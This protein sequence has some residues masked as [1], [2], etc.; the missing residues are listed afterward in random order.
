MVTKIEEIYYIIIVSC[1]YSKPEILINP[2]T[3]TK[4]WNIVHKVTLSSDLEI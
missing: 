3:H 1:K 4:I 2:H